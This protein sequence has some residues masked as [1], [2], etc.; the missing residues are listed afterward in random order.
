M[1]TIL[2]NESNFIEIR[3]SKFLG[4]I[5]H[6]ET[7]DDFYALLKKL[8]KN[9][10]HA[11]HIVYAYLIGNK[12]SGYSDANEPKGTAGVPILNVLKKNDLCFVSLFIIRY[13]G[14]IKLGTGGLLRAYTRTASELVLKSVKKELIPA[15]EILFT[16]K[17]EDA[18][19]FLIQYAQNRIFITEKKYEE[20]VR[21]HGFAD[22]QTLSAIKNDYRVSSLKIIRNNFLYPF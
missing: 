4:Y 17:Y 6:T 16:L 22:N 14:G 8:K 2:V 12:V 3:K 21:I 5:F 15:S 9:N 11:D 19:R 1:L 13:F 10:P 18:D 20:N 7:L